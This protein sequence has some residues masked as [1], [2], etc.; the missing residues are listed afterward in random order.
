MIPAA[1]IAIDRTAG[2]I[3]VVV[4]GAC[5]FRGA[6]YPLAELAQQLREWLHRAHDGE[7]AP[8]FVFRPS[9][10][11]ELLGSFRLEPRPVGWQFTSTREKM[12]H[13][14][15]LSFDEVRAMVAGFLRDFPA[16]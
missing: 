4:D 14:R 13:D 10:A 9:S 11:P 5:L 16:A 3:A 6:S 12:R 7:N 15:L 2:N 1:S 8:C